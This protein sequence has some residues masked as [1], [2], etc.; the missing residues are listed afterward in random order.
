MGHLGIGLISSSQLRRVGPGLR[1][2][3]KFG[4]FRPEWRLDIKRNGSS[5][6][7]LPLRLV[8]AS[9]E[10]ASSRRKTSVWAHIPAKIF[11][12]R[13]CA[14]RGD[15]RRSCTFFRGESRRLV[16]SPA[17]FWVPGGIQAW[18]GIPSRRDTDSSARDA[19][20][21]WRRPPG[22]SQ[23]RCSSTLRPYPAACTM[24]SIGGGP[25]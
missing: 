3:S 24:R 4:M 12:G 10:V 22:P 5:S 25:R 2:G 11:S 23:D 21:P 17:I 18:P 16:P 13:G 19:R 7:C 15:S 9:S 6:I 20:C 8:A 1:Q 14:A